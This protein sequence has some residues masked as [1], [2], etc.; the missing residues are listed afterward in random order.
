MML[1]AVL[2]VFSTCILSG[3]VCLDISPLYGPRV[4]ESG[5]EAAVELTCS[6]AHNA[7]E[8]NQLDVKCYFQRTAQPFIQ[9]VPSAGRLPQSIGES[10]AD[11]LELSHSFLNTSHTLRMRLKR[12]TVEYSGLYEC[13]VSTFHEEKTSSLNMIVFDPG[14]GP[15]L[16][17]HTAEDGYV[18]I[19][20]SALRVFPEPSLH[21]TW[22]Y[23]ETG[24]ELTKTTVRRGLEFDVTVH[25]LLPPTEIQAE[26]VFSCS[27]EI[28]GTQ[29]SLRKETMYFPGH[30]QPR[31]SLVSSASWT[32]AWP[33]SLLMTGLLL[34]LLLLAVRKE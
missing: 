28:P 23:G 6:F 16:S 14:E 18:N 8:L 9:W 30:I 13:K 17:Y 22:N 25:R 5:Q 12:P 11:R 10:W 32:A 3:H 2:T 33:P 19:S 21:L 29:F 20:C 34:L 15:R 24:D 1:A 26:T 31:A 27:M 4:V 7:S